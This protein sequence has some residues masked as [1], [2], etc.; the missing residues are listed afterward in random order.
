MFNNS[1]HY[2]I[3][4]NRIE[5]VNL[6]LANSFNLQTFLS[7]TELLKLYNDVNINLFH[8]FRDFFFKFFYLDSEKPLLEFI[9]HS[10][11]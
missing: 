1:M 6:F 2:A 3:L 7:R 8:L 4:N 9:V 11:N 10:K 5:F